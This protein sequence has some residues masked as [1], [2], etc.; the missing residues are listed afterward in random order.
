M[1]DGDRVA[2]RFT[3]RGTHRGPFAGAP[4]RVGPS[5]S[6]AARTTASP[7]ASSPRS[8]CSPTSSACCGRSAS[9]CEHV[10]RDM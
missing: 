5:R 3:L 8:A 10:P 7:A 6:A 9:N 1:V 2:A 4:P